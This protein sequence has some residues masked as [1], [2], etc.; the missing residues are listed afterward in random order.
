LSEE[1]KG[2]ECLG[3]RQ[4]W[5]YN[6]K[7]ALRVTRCES[8]DC[9]RRRSKGCLFK[10]IVVNRVLKIAGFWDIEPCSLE[11]DQCF[12]DA[13]VCLNETTQSHVLEGFHLHTRR[14][15]NLKSHKF[16]F[17]RLK[18]D[19]SS[20]IHCAAQLIGYMVTALKLPITG[21]IL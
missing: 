13:S 17:T 8:R 16:L 2:L 9:L 12:K 7:M 10:Y 18:L 19:N 5:N 6:I 11:V 15:E 20:S 4:R 14:L 1:V 3:N 21:Q